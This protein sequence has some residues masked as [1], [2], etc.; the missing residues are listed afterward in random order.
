V[1]SAGRRFVNESD[2]YHDVVMGML[3]SQETVPSV[4]AHL[5]CDAAFLRSYGLGLALPGAR[6]RRRLVKAGYLIEAP[7]LK[8]LASR[9]GV[10]AAELQRTVQRHNTFAATGID[11]DFGRG[12]S[13][14][15]RFNG[16]P[17]N[18]PNPCMRPIVTAPYYA[19]AVWPA[20]LAG[21]AG[22]KGDIDGRVLDESGEPIPGLFACGNDLTS[23]FRGTYP[24]PGTT[25]GPAM[26]FGWRIAKAAAKAAHSPS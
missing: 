19:V 4:P 23:I 10:D 24:G 7:D 15:N 8:T 18:T 12:T 26:V 3:R 20:D 1:N 9:I 2:S 25:I 21:S 22:L 5:I 6:G 13:A 14:M 11:E 17:A 16:D